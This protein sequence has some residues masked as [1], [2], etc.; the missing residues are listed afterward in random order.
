MTNFLIAVSRALIY[1]LCW[2]V[3]PINQ[4]FRS[5]RYRDDDDLLRELEDE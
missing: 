3:D 2:L 5:K 1:I 4:A